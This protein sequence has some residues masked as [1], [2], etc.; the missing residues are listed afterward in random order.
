MVASGSLPFL[1]ISYRLNNSWEEKAPSLRD[2]GW[3]S[4]N[5]S[6]GARFV[7][8]RAT[9]S[10]YAQPDVIADVHSSM[11]QIVMRR[12][13]FWASITFMVVFVLSSVGNVSVA[14]GY[15]WDMAV[16]S[17]PYLTSIALVSGGIVHFVKND[18][19]VYVAFWSSICMAGVIALSVARNVKVSR[20]YASEV[21]SDCLALSVPLLLLVGSVFLDKQ[22]GV[23]P[24]L[25][26]LRRAGSLIPLLYVVSP[27]FGLGMYSLVSVRN[28]LVASH[29]G[30]LGAVNFAVGV[31]LVSILYKYV[32]TKGDQIV[33]APSPRHIWHEFKRSCV[34]GTSD[35]LSIASHVAGFFVFVYAALT[36]G[37]YLKEYC[38]TFL[39]AVSPVVMSAL[40]GT[41]AW[42][43]LYGMQQVSLYTSIAWH[44]TADWL[45]WPV[46]GF[47]GCVVHWLL[48]PLHAFYFMDTTPYFF[49]VVV[50]FFSSFLV[51]LLFRVGSKVLDMCLL[52][53]LNFVKLQNMQDENSDRAE[54]SLRW[55]LLHIVVGATVCW[56]LSHVTH[57]DGSHLKH[58]FGAW[59]GSISTYAIPVLTA[60]SET[61]RMLAGAYVVLLLCLILLPIIFQHVAGL[62]FGDGRNNHNQMVQVTTPYQY[63]MDPINGN[64]DDALS[65]VLAQQE[66]A[67]KKLLPAMVPRALSGS[68]ASRETLSDVLVRSQENL[69]RMWA[70]RLMVDEFAV[71]YVP[72]FYGGTTATLGGI[73]RTLAW[74]DV[75]KMMRAGDADT[76]RDF[77]CSHWQELGTVC[78]ATANAIA[79]QLEVHITHSIV[80]ILQ[81][82]RKEADLPHQGPLSDWLPLMARLRPNTSVTFEAKGENKLMQG[83]IFK[84]HNDGLYNIDCGRRG[85]FKRVK[86]A[87]ISPMDETDNGMGNAQHTRLL[88]IWSV[89][90]KGNHQRY[91]SKLGRF[92]GYMSIFKPFYSV[93]RRAMGVQS[94]QDPL[95]ALV[96][97]CG[98]HA[99]ES[100]ASFLV[101]GSEEDCAV[102]VK[103]F[104]PVA[105]SALLYLEDVLR[106]YDLVVELCR[107]LAG[108]D[109]VRGFQSK[110]ST[111]RSALA[112]AVDES[113]HRIVLAFRL[114]VPRHLLAANYRYSTALERRLQDITMAVMQ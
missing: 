38:M 8:R 43:Q 66:Q 10:L 24:S 16:D 112:M 71:P 1:S 30:A 2:T 74:Q 11:V 49:A 102:Q 89:V 50:V 45:L 6:L 87:A 23:A 19:A 67:L 4:N 26:F 106:A 61:L 54:A 29:P 13:A 108:G 32:S 28:D 76:R 96:V 21:A 100:L 18:L 60:A 33:L 86:E 95:P 69:M 70:D 62:V 63:M 68:A 65:E 88:K 17:L 94:R 20:G 42:K 59:L 105:L 12:I 81:P 31:T 109:G 113:L 41:E 52:Y 40:E 39:A 93:A 97:Q 104:L 92:F 57:G 90:R 111:W 110:S 48:W 44:F 114:S 27:L 80:E 73:M 36:V 98:V 83:V 64:G 34:E 58:L 78:C 37:S 77:L 3:P 51:S 103:A 91:D 107:P 25:S 82:A 5:K 85:I 9:M 75:S 79:L 72:M 15:L 46:R 56:G 22:V 55:K 7:R 35:S 101:K 14:P 99:V 47:V 84:D 53:P